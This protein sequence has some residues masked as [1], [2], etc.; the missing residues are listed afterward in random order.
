LR[1]NQFEIPYVKLDMQ[2]IFC[3]LSHYVDLATGLQKKYYERILD[4]MVYEIVY[5]EVF[6]AAKVSVINIVKEFPVLPYSDVDDVNSI[7]NKVYL[8]QSDPKS[9]M[10]ILLL[11]AIDLKEIIN[12]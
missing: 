9:E 7:V 6:S 11:K 12:S 2:N 10:S 5:R 3:N 8:E 4:L 1:I